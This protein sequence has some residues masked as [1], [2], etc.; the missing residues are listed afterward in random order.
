MSERQR[1]DAGRELFKRR[2]QGVKHKDDIFLVPS[3]SEE[4]L[5]HRVDFDKETC[6]CEDFRFNKT[7]KHC[8]VAVLASARLHAKSK[9]A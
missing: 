3:E 7:C 6:D 4:G 8:Y 2:R 1:I 5:F 9:K